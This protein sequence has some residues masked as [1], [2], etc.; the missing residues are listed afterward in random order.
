M[1]GLIYYEFNQQ[2]SEN[3]VF[4]FVSINKPA[5]SEDFAGFFYYP[6]FSR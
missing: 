1:T 6:Y 2:I 5:T 3:Q 4:T